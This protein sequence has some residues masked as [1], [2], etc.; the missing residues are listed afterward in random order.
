[1]LGLV[2]TGMHDRVRGLTP[3][4]GK[5]ISVYNQ[6]PWSTQPPHPSVGR[7]NEY[8]PKG[9]DAPCGSGVKAGMVFEWVADKTV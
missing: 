8:Q 6:S 4:V 2:S 7:C 3:S 9:G 5:S 1:M